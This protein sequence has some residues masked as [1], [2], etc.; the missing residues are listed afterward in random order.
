MLSKHIG[1]CLCDCLQ[2][3]GL[4]ADGA[5]QS[6]PE[7]PQL[8]AFRPTPRVVPAALESGMRPGTA[9]E[10]GQRHLEPFMGT[11]RPLVSTL[12]KNADPSGGACH[13]A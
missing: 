12:A 6:K 8:Q 10:R 9:G 1:C 2:F 13:E 11:I 5:R 4:P 3:R 7:A